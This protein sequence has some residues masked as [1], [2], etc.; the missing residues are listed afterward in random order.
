MP[1]KG[2]FSSYPMAEIQR[3]K[4]DFTGTGSVAGYVLDSRCD[5]SFLVVNELLHAGLDVYRFKNETGVK[6]LTGEGSFFVPANRKAK[7]LLEQSS[8]DLS[9]SVRSSKSPA[10]SSDK[11]NYPL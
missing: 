10:C 9:L 4:G 5:Q 8:S 3:P 6:P 7:A 11:E 1:L 2:L